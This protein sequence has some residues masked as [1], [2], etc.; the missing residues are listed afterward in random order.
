MAIEAE[1]LCGLLD[2]R[3]RFADR[4]LRREI[5]AQRHRGEL[6]LVVDRNR[7]DRR[8]DLGDLAQRHLLAAGRGRVNAAQRVRPE[9]EIG[10]DF[11]NHEILVEP[12]IDP[13]R[14]SLAG[15]I[16]EDGSRTDGLMPSCCASGR[17][18]STFMTRL[19]LC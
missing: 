6:A 12:C 7:G 5:E 13:R 14:D 16:V 1:L 11:E 10:L 15:R 4:D 2:R 18:T 19:V 8:G 3:H 9:L 17:L